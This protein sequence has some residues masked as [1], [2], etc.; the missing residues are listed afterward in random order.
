MPPANDPVVSTHTA[1]DDVL[2]D[3]P[4]HSA[5]NGANVSSETTPLLGPPR[6]SSLATAA[7]PGQSV[8]RKWTVRVLVG[9][10]VALGL[11][12]A[13][14]VP[15][16]YFVYIP[17]RLQKGS[18]EGTIQL[19]NFHIDA[20]G[21]DSISIRLNATQFIRE[22]LLS[23]FSCPMS[24]FSSATLAP[25]LRP[26][27]A[28]VPRSSRPGY[29]SHGK[30]KTVTLV[31]LTKLLQSF[32]PSPSPVLSPPKMPPPSKLYSLN[33]LNV[34]TPPSS[35]ILSQTHSHSRSPPQP[36]TQVLPQTLHI[37]STRC[38]SDDHPESGT[39]ENPYVDL[40][41]L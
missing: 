3:P 9:G 5:A 6:G 24:T 8:A 19:N 23:T 16:V 2:S 28:P 31:S 18:G 7:T 20:I 14:V 37:P 10:L 32:F 39:L 13:T 29:L 33:P 12:V 40:P 41:P 27:V 4:P 15:V 1:Q 22:P 26:P 30:M 11:V 21:N 25:H 36:L 17:L 35:L 38:P 34:L